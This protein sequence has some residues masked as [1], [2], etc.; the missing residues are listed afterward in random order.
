MAAITKLLFTFMTLLISILVYEDGRNIL[1]SSTGL[2]THSSQIVPV[3]QGNPVAVGVVVGMVV[4]VA[5]GA[6]VGVTAGVALGVMIG[7]GVGEEG[8]ARTV[9]VSTTLVALVITR[10]IS[11]STV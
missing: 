5:A 2:T 10:K 3:A 7:L 6:A 8:T 9:V 11:S 1:T 4:G